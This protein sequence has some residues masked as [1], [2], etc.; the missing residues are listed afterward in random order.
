MDKSFLSAE[1]LERIK[2]HPG[3]FDA[4][5]GR[6]LVAAFA[7][8]VVGASAWDATSRRAG[9]CPLLCLVSICYTK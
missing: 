7:G 8:H 2:Q 3:F 4:M 5:L 6:Q 1:I 9:V